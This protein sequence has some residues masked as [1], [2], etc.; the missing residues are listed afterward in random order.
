[1]WFLLL[2]MLITERFPHWRTAARAH[3]TFTTRDIHH[4]ASAGLFLTEIFP[5][6][7][8]R[9]VTQARI[10]QP[11]LPR[12]HTAPQPPARPPSPRQHREPNRCSRGLDGTGPPAPLTHRMRLSQSSGSAAFASMASASSRRP[13]PPLRAAAQASDARVALTA[14]TTRG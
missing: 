1:M 7:K 2:M 12:S 14:G 3:R 5:V 13:P 4:T 9:F 10:S 11:A 6:F 8:H